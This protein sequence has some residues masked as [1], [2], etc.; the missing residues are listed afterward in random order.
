MVPSVGTLLAGY[1]ENESSYPAW[2]H[3]SRLHVGY[4]GTLDTQ[5]PSCRRGLRI[6][7]GDWEPSKLVW[8]EKPAARNVV[9]WAY[10]HR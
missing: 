8:L 1:S 9:K 3:W 5:V 4:L 6:R 7:W 10:T 2:V